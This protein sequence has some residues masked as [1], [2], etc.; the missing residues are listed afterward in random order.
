MS[1]RL[2]GWSG[3]VFV[4][5]IVLSAITFGDAPSV[6]DDVA[7][8][9]EYLASDAS[10]HRASGVLAALA[11]PFEAVFL[12]GIIATVRR[13]AGD[14]DEI[15][16]D[17]ARFGAITTLI[18]V[19]LGDVLL[20][21]VYFRDEAAGL[22]DATIRMLWDGQLIAY[23]VMGAGVATLTASVAVASLRGGMWP[24]WH[25][26]LGFVVAVTGLLAPFALLSATNGAEWL[27]ALVFPALLI[28]SLASAILLIRKP[29]REAAERDND[30]L[31]AT[32][33][34]DR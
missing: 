8:I 9:R 12:A 10:I 20:D 3:V 4:V 17:V 5:V 24:R 2:A 19:L 11:I 30:P 23:S 22:D 29:V 32:S 28:W 1:R 15:W 18:C 14:G 16:A 7:S 34:A 25:A 27:S 21:V 6:E 13:P 26:A 31:A 33:Q